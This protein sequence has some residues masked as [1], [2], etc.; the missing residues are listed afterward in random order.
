[1]S[2]SDFFAD[3][4]AWFYARREM[5][6]KMARLYQQA[7]AIAAAVAGHDAAKLSEALEQVEDK[8][9]Y[10]DAYYTRD[11][12]AAINNGRLEV[13]QALHTYVG[14]SNRMLAEQI[15]ISTRRDQEEWIAFNRSPLYFSIEC[16]SHDIALH[17]LDDPKTDVELSGNRGDQKLPRPL[18][19]VADKGIQ[20]VHAKLLDREAALYRQRADEVSARYRQQADEMEALSHKLV[21]VP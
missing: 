4:A 7:A 12:K 20:D 18:D 13:F 2:L 3:P 10:L 6:E 19:V 17:L 14:D 1:M 16:R 21:P 15:D 5:A 8:Q 11:M 9:A